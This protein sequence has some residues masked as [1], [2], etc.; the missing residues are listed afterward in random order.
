MAES[1]INIVFC[2]IDWKQSRHVSTKTETKNLKIL[3]GTLT[4]I[5]SQLSPDVLALC[6]VG[7]ASEPMQ[8]DALKQIESTITTT[9]RACMLAPPAPA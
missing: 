4:S 6:E 2:N 5:I 1:D 3:A 8:T 9:W 7:E